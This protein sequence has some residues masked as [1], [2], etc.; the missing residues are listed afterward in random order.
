MT[1]KYELRERAE[2]MAETRRRIVEAAVDLHTSIGPASTSISAIAERAGVQRHTL[3]AHFPD[4]DAL[5][6]ACSAHWRALHPVPDVRGLE[7]PAALSALYG[8]YE[9]VGGALAVLSRD[10]AMYPEIWSGQQRAFA[11]MAE[12]LARPLGRGKLVRAAVGHALALETWRSLTLREGL[13]RAQ[14]VDAMLAFIDGTRRGVR[15]PG[16]PR[17]KDGKPTRA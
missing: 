12:D 5:F 16:W 8:W 2:H 4:T 6:R 10:A 11:K 9:Q 14:A 1:R 15:S 13:T 7:L 3:Y 17:P